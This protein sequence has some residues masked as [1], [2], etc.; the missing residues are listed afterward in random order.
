MREATA[1][2]SILNVAKNSV[3]IRRE[4][5]TF[6]QSKL[7]AMNLLEGDADG[8]FGSAT[9][10]ALKKFQEQEKLPVTQLPDLVTLLRLIERKV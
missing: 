2:V 7:K 1:S 4:T 5:L 10:T 9:Q 8:S 3:E 6:A